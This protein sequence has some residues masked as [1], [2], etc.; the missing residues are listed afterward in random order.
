LRWWEEIEEGPMK[1]SS[2]KDSDE[3]MGWTELGPK[4]DVDVPTAIIASDGNKP[5]QTGPSP[6]FGLIST[7][8][9]LV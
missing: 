1:K 6:R 7:R 3:I 9:L 5:N 8:N 4:D 2:W